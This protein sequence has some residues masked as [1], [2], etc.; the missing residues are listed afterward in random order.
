MI[1]IPGKVNDGWFGQVRFKG[2]GGEV[3]TASPVVNPYLQGRAENTIARGDALSRQPRDFFP[4]QTFAGFDPLQTQ[5]Q[6]LQAQR[7]LAGSPLN[8]G[9]QDLAQQTLGGQFLSPGSNPNL[10]G[11]IDAS[12]RP[13]FEQ[14]QQRTLPGITSQFAAGS[15]RFGGEGQAQREVTQHA[16]ERA[17]QQASDQAARL[18]MGAYGQER[19]LQQQ[20]MFGAP[21]LA[22]QDYADIARVG[23]VGDV[24]QGQ[25]Q[26]G[27][28][29]QMARHQFGQEEPYNALMRQMG[30]IQGTAP[31]FGMGQQT[32]SGSGSNPIMGAL[33][34]LSTGAGIVG[35]LGAAGIGMSNPVMAGLIGAPAIA[36]A[37]M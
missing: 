11:A 33:G 25:Q 28:Q 1:P 3:Q 22:Q 15:G 8:Q 24:R 20:A 27:I 19:E 32:T 29:D 31:I 4:G 13:I 36:G 35:G 23:A 6:D 5:A 9:A 37:F 7:G 18:A 30:L 26:R 14:L 17:S 2:G 10:Q 12:T 34:G 16:T 21:Q